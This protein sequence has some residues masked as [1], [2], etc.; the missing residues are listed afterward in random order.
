MRKN[1]FGRQLKRDKN[2]RKALFKGLISSLVLYGR[3]K[4]TEEKAKAIKGQIDKIITRAKKDKTGINSKLERYLTSDAF[5]KLIGEVVPSLTSR[6][7]GYTRIIR[8]GE[9]F[10]D[11]AS[12][13]ILE[14][15]DLEQIK[16]QKSKIK[17]LKDEKKEKEEKLTEEKDS[18]QIK[19]KTRPKRVRK[20]KKDLPAG[21]QGKNEK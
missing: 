18:K 15:V 3:I 6:N 17:N 14:W 7:S 20:V 8:L 12:T 4:T 19:E 9:R 5:K 21:R 13:V 1:V 16:N 2:E 11:A 10:S